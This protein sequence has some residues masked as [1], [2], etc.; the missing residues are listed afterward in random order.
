MKTQNLTR[1]QFL[2]NTAVLAGSAALIPFGIQASAAPANTTKRTAVDQV[3]L[4]NT[5]LT[6]SRLGFGTGSNS[7]N[8]QY[9]LGQAG[10][11]RLIHYAYDQGIT[12]F[13]CSVSYRTHRWLGAAIKGLPREKLYIQT[14]VDGVPPKPLEFID[15]IR[16]TY[17]TDYVDSLLIHCA[18]HPDWDEKR[19]RMLDAVVEAQSRKWVRVRGVSCHSLPALRRAQEIDWPQ[20]HLVRMN[21]Q[22]AHIDTPREAVWVPSNPSD[23]PAVMAQMKAMRAKGRGIIAMKLI[24]NGDFTR[25]ED[26]EKAIRFDFQSGLPDAAVIG[27]KSASEIDE[28][29]KRINRALAPA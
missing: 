28:A 1:R 25:A 29:I 26:R 5:G 10:F 15:R 4:G 22:G 3:P 24:G 18:I 7:G 8:V 6:L 27:F 17:D 2:E 13:D 21:P 23:L 19:K 14:K 12:Y 9:R 11:N 16:H 20:V